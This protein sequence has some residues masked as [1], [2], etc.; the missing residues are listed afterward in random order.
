MPPHSMSSLAVI[1][2]L[3][4]LACQ[5]ALNKVIKSK[6]LFPRNVL[7]YVR[8]NTVDSRLPGMD[9]INFPNN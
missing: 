1:L 7:N 5:W 4:H 2:D 6:L 9:E 3:M 8:L